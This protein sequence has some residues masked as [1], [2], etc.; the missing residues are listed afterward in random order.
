MATV[1]RIHKSAKIESV[2]AKRPSK[3]T[4]LNR[5]KYRVT[6]CTAN[7]SIDNQNKLRSDFLTMNDDCIIAILN[8]LEVKDLPSIA[9]TSIRMQTLARMAFSSKFRNQRVVLVET[10]ETVEDCLRNFGSQI[11]SICL[12]RPSDIPS[13]QGDGSSISLILIKHCPLL[14][15]LKLHNYNFGT[16]FCDEVEAMMARLRH[17][18][19][20]SE[21]FEVSICRSPV[22]VA[23]IN[24]N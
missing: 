17:I 7:K 4:K 10:E 2:P 15:D 22:G 16:G 1:K 14:T 20:S 8:H 23:P 9:N 12:K 19:L 6:G 21:V 24:N 3:S 13:R 5:S 11:H 18:C